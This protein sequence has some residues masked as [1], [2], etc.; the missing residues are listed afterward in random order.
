NQRQLLYG[1]Y[2]IEADETA[3]AMAT[4]IVFGSDT[5]KT[6]EDIIDYFD[7]LGGQ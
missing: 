2:L 3:D 7:R 5:F 6:W 4:S 1:D